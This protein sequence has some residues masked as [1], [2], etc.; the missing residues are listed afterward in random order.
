[1]PGIHRRP[2]TLAAGIALAGL[3]GGAALCWTAPAAAATYNSPSQDD[4][5]S[6]VILSSNAYRGYEIPPLPAGVEWTEVAIANWSTALL[7]RTDGAIDVVAPGGSAP[8]TQ[9]VTV[10]ELSPGVT[11]THVSGGRTIAALLRSDGQIAFAYPGS[12]DG[13]PISVP[14]LPAGETYVA[15]DLSENLVG[16]LRSDGRI[17]VFPA[18]F[19]DRATSDDPAYFVK[20]TKSTKWDQVSVGQSFAIGLTSKGAL[21]SFDYCEP[22][23]CSRFERQGVEAVTDLP[24]AHGYVDVSADYFSAAVV[25]DDG[26]VSFR[27]RY[28]EDIEEPTPPGDVQYTGVNVAGEGFM[29]S[30]SDGQMVVLDTRGHTERLPK[31]PLGWTFSGSSGSSGLSAY[32]MHRIGA[33]EKVQSS[34]TDVNQKKVATTGKRTKLAVDVFSRASTVGGKVQVYF[35]GKKV[36][37]DRV[38]SPNTATVNIST[39]KMKAEGAGDHEV[40]VKF[41]GHGSA[42]K[43]VTSAVVRTK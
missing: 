32:L 4:H 11:Y 39:K 7:L 21:K 30:R 10:P 14:A 18:T 37:V 2:R 24:S 42:L 25:R 3:V 28:L 29:L 36:G 26:A 1:M 31:N 12:Y 20:T 43:S 17:V 6:Q 15:V 34:I 22:M 40:K 38:T 9:A 33:D 27:G 5:E 13:D 41:L 23:D 35:E 8:A 16:A 19:D